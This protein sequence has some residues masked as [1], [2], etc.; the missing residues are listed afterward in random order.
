MGRDCEARDDWAATAQ[1]KL[2]EKQTVGG[3]YW[4]RDFSYTQTE[5]P[6]PVEER[7]GS[8]WT[9]LGASARGGCGAV[10]L[11]TCVRPAHA[12]KVPCTG[13]SALPGFAA[14]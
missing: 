5:P 7:S 2:A 11:E 1:K 3:E 10:W 14:T 9:A 6:T 4:K 12:L 13:S 8:P